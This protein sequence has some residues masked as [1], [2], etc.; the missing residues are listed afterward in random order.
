[1]GIASRL[2]SNGTYLVNSAGQTGGFDEWTGTPV[3]DSSLV[4]WLDAGQPS[5][6]PGTG[7]TWTDLSGKGNNGTLVNSPTYNSNGSLAF[8]GISKYIDCGPVSQIGSSL[9]G[10]TV[11]AWIYPTSA[12]T[13]CIMENGTAYNQNTFY[14]FQENSTQFTFAVMGP[15]TYN[16]VYAN[17][18]YQLN[19]WY[20][21]VGVWS[22]GATN[23]LYAN[24]VDCSGAIVGVAQTILING[25]TNL[26]VGSRAGVS[27]YYSGNI[28]T[29]NLYNRALTAT[30]V[31]QNYNALAP[32]YN[33][34]KISAVNSKTKTTTSTVLANSLDEVT[35]STVETLV[36]AGG[37]SGVDD[38]GGA[39]GAGGLLYSSAYP[40]A[41]GTA[42]TVTVGTGAPAGSSRGL[43]NNGGNSIFNTLIAIGGGSG[44]TG[45]GVNGIAGGSGGGA[46]NGPGKDAIT[47]GGAGTAG[48]GFNGGASTYTAPNYGGGG[49]GGAGGPGSN[50]TSLVGGNGGSGL[51]Y[52]ISGTS[53]WYAGG[54]GG[55]A[56]G[57]A[58]YTAG[59]GGL[60]GGGNGGNGTN[61]TSGTPNTGGGGGSN[62]TTSAGLAGGS[63]I[64][65]IRYLGPQTATGGTITSIG[66]YTIHTFTSTGTFATAN[67]PTKRETNTGTVQVSGSFDEWTGAPV[68]DSSLAL[69][70]DAGQS[71]SYSGTGT[72]WTDLSGK[73][74][75]GILYNSPTYASDGSLAFNGSTQYGLCSGAIP[76]SGSSAWTVSGWFKRTGNY[77][78]GAAWGFGTAGAATNFNSYNLSNTNQI[79]IDL[80]GT[81]TFSS[82]QSF[83][84]NTWTFATWVFNG[85]VFTR[86]NMTMWKN[87]V[88]YTGAALS[89]LRGN[90]ATTPIINPAGGIA[91]SRVS[92]AD[93][94]Y[95]SPMTIADI[96][97]YNR[98]LTADEIQTNFNALRGRYGI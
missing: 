7:T 33:L 88:S 46:G 40:V 75:N 70:L 58:S 76:V 18:T 93:N 19:T 80:Y 8:N 36:V 11:E 39:G 69:W 31:Q 24:G 86:A 34:A 10:L 83:D 90:E 14:M 45:S 57:G 50:G 27:Y 21:L 61:G 96:K 72:T 73:G 43:G 79:A 60:G 41:P 42:Y 32:R 63:G 49:G 25:N 30:E 5:S 28:S 67:L 65:I 56:Y 84:L 17:F 20:H 9:T 66:G 26:M 15:T 23:K 22:A 54:G 97:I 81:S 95:Y 6:Y 52:A 55:G 29:A 2:T 13:Q 59:I 62:G 51:Q 92:A 4:V 91:L 87:S 47:V 12:S 78:G 64:V 82:G 77:V 44:G 98:V 85:G 35:L 89:V 94:G 74:N 71:S 37:G 68:V 3:V 53:T 48:Q 38:R 16:V 1:M